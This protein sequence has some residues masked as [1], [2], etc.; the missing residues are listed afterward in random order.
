MSLL[1]NFIRPPMELQLLQQC[2][3]HTMGLKY[4]LRESNEH[5]TTTSGR[6]RAVQQKK[7][8]QSKI[9]DFQTHLHKISAN[10]FLSISWSS[11]KRTFAVSSREALTYAL[12][13]ADLTVHV[14][15]LLCR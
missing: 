13:P 12:N 11:K 9:T 6:C 5:I 15:H 10:N 4:Q 14:S 2:D 1:T 3:A 7:D 8:Q